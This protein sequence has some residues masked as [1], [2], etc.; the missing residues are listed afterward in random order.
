MS[1]VVLLLELCFRA[2]L[3]RF[4]GT[5]AACL[6]LRHALVVRSETLFFVSA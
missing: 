5:P 1:G 3:V 6:Y 2:S 4:S